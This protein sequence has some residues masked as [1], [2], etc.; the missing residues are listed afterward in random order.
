MGPVSQLKKMFAPTR[1]IATIVMIVNILKLK[2]NFNYY[3]YCFFNQF[4][5]SL[6]LT[7]VS[8]FLV[9]S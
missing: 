6:V 8:A 9:N 7:L 3:I 1:L 5:A 2:L 4:K